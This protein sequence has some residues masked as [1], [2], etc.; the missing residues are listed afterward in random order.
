MLKQRTIRMPDTAL[1]L[2]SWETFYVIIGSASAALT[3]L[4]FVVVT[5]ISDSNQTASEDGV[6]AFAT[7]NVLHFCAALL[8]SAILTAPWSAIWQPA[9]AIALVGG[10]GLVYVFIFLQRARRQTA[11]KP[12]FEDWLWHFILAFLAYATL[13]AAGF[14]E[15]VH[16][17]GA[18]FAVAGAT[19]LLLFIGIHNAW[20]TVTYLSLERLRA[21]QKA[22]A[23]ERGKHT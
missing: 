18:L 5:L 14:V 23:Q 15:A 4:M 17:S 9:W 19:T 16:S 12:V 3:G 22:K 20:D 10:A 8:V 7:P 2:K 13:A 1:T 11:Y 21:R 6:S